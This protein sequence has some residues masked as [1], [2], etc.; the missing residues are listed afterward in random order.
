MRGLISQLVRLLGRLLRDQ[1]IAPTRPA[2]GRPSDY[3]GLPPMVF[4]RGG[5][6]GFSSGDMVWTWVPYEEDARQGKDRPVLLI[7]ADG[8][9]LLGLP[10]TSK[11]HD[12]DAA[13]E[14]R[15]GRYWIDI[16]TGEWDSQRRPSEVR[17]DRI[18]RVDPHRVRR[19]A[20]RVRPDIFDEVAAAVSRH[21]ND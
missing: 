12:R 7:G 8:N 3:P 2:P 21:W 6:G 17:V 10:A 5:P 14:R 16:G 4:G 11:D 9:W 18:V 20:G 1:T 13:Q 19:S 15:A